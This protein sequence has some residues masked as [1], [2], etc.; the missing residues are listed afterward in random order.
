LFPCCPALTVQD[1]LLQQREELF[2]G[3]I[4]TACPGAAHG[5]GQTVAAQGGDEG[6]R[7]ELAAL[8]E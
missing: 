2:D 1:V 8:S 4:V 3:G 6:G 7:P 5:S